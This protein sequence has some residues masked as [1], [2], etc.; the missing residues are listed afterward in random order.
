L[1]DRYQTDLTNWL[2][3]VHGQVVFT[4]MRLDAFDT[5]T[6]TNE[7]T[8]YLVKLNPPATNHLDPP[9]KISP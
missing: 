3:R 2:V 9:Q 8:W 7:E 5:H 4:L 6:T 1:S